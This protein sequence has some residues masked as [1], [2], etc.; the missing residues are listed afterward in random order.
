[1]KTASILSLPAIIAVA[2]SSSACAQTARPPAQTTTPAAAAPEPVPAPGQVIREVPVEVRAAQAPDPFAKKPAPPDSMLAPVP[3]RAPKSVEAAVAYHMN[4]ARAQ[5]DRPAVI[6]TEPMTPEVQTELREDLNVMDKLLSDATMRSGGEF[7]PHAMGIKLMM[8]GPSEPAYIE[9]LG[10]LFSYRVSF[11]LAAGKNRGDST[12]KPAGPPSAWERARRELAARENPDLMSGRYPSAG[13][14]AAQ[15]PPQFDQAKLDQ[16][17]DGILK[18]LPE[19]VNMR[20]LRDGDSVV[21]TVVGADED[22]AATRLT[23]RARKADI[24]QANRGE[25]PPEEF[26]K[27]VARRV[28]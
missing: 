18:V 6:V 4:A 7:L 5:A 12:T 13:R 19:A 26:A 14:A 1:M 17:I 28:G 10:A 21:V 15:E 9:G 2:L 25:L 20:H 16:M 8:I 27:R 22:G 3:A 24:E 11:P 23:L